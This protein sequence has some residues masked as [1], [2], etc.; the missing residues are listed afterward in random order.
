M[1]IGC[2]SV[3]RISKTETKQHLQSLD[4]R[5]V[6][7]V[8]TTAAGNDLSAQAARNNL[9]NAYQN[10]QSAQKQQE[11][12]SSYHRRLIEKGCQEGVTT[13][14]WKLALMRAIMAT[15]PNRKLR[16]SSN[17]FKSPVRRSPIVMRNGDLHE[18]TII[19]HRKLN[20]IM[21]KIIL[22]FFQALLWL[23]KPAVLKLEAHE[24]GDAFNWFRSR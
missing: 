11:A 15:V 2:S 24:H 3:R 21:N 13:L 4:Q 5:T 14:H 16:V 19:I 17:R 12:A 22:P 1:Q 18:I 10:F 23:R 20:Q 9:L 7:L 8:A 6:I